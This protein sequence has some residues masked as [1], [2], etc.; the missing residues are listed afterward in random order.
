M[1]HTTGGAVAAASG[2]GDFVPET[3]GPS[4]WTSVITSATTASRAATTAG[5]RKALSPKAACRRPPEIAPK[6]SAAQSGAWIQN[7]GEGWPRS[8]LASPHR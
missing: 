6:V 3:S 1:R 5:T 7:D 4:P 2:A 8:R